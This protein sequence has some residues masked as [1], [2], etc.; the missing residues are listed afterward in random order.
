MEELQRSNGYVVLTGTWP[1]I[2]AVRFQHV[3]D[4]LA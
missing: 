2:A 3:T 4:E 1:V